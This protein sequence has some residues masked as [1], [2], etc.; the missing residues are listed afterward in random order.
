MGSE[1]VSNPR[2]LLVPLQFLLPHCQVPFRQG[3]AIRKRK[4]TTTRSTFMR[5]SLSYGGRLIV[6]CGGKK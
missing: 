4:L 6:R 2:Q 1:R 5:H 3:I